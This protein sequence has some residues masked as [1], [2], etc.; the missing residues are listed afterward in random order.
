[1]KDHAIKDVG[2]REELLEAFKSEDKEI[3]IGVAGV[4]EE[5]GWD[6]G[7]AMEDL[8]KMYRDDDK[9]VS[10]AAL[11]AIRTIDERELPKIGVSRGKIA[12]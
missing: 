1:L 6:G 10:D 5:M 3:R 11:R 2:V 7:A 9:R 8:K 4:F 12:K